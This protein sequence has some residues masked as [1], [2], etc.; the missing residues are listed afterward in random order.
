MDVEIKFG[1]KLAVIKVHTGDDP[2]VLAEVRFNFP[3]ELFDL[4]YMCAGVCEAA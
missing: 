4:T 2:Y 1:G 3:I